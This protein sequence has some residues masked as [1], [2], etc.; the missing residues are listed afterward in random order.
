MAR[1][2][3]CFGFK[4]RRR[5]RD[6]KRK[7]SFTLEFA[8]L[9]APFFLLIVGVSELCLIEGAQQMLESAAYN[10]SRIG[11]TGY[12]G[13]DGS[14]AD[15]V[16]QVFTNQLSSYGGFFNTALLKTTET[17]Y[18]SFS[19]VAAGGGTSG[20]GSASQIVVYTVTYPWKIFTPL[21]CNLFGSACY[22]TATGSYVNLT[23]TIVVRNE[24]YG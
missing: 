16:N 8:L 3:S 9:A 4:G 12:T 13:T 22:T 19:G 14:Q 18:S 15:T 10:A 24:P 7:G 6:I 23:S 11:K 21:M 1:F 2:L 20:Y 17:D 5:G